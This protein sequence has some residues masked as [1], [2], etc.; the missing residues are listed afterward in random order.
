M[1][2]NKELQEKLV[3][4]RMLEDRM[5]S[6]MQQRNLMLNKLPEID[7]TKETLDEIS[8]V[9]GNEILVSIGSATY[10]TGK[11]VKN[12]KVIVEIGAGVA[13]EK[14]IDDAIKILKKRR[15]NL[16]DAINRFDN[17][18]KKT[19]ETI[20]NLESDIRKLTVREVEY[21]AG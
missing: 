6:L 21:E 17:E 10:A 16:E 15:E 9:D 19:G 20:T 11:L 13:L 2:K 1:K 8:K 7:I 12:D 4:Y 14:P 5:N 3:H 18:I